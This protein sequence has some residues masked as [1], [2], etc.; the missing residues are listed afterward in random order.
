MTGDAR[1]WGSKLRCLWSFVLR[2]GGEF[3]G[4]Q[5]RP[6]IS[7]SHWGPMDSQFVGVLPVVFLKDQQPD[8][9]LSPFQLFRLL[10]WFLL[11]PGSCDWRRGVR[12]EGRDLLHTRKDLRGPARRWQ[13]R[14]RRSALRGCAALP[15]DILRSEGMCERLGLGGGV[16]FIGFRP[17]F[18]STLLLRFRHSQAMVRR[19][20]GHCN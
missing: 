1:L 14:G 9:F 10:L 5:N 4:S 2:R 15:G 8:S 12:A 17:L 19:R 18:A 6:R 3:C 11:L 7:V 20:S 13:R 16:A